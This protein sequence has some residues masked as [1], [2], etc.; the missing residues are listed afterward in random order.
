MQQK[1]LS[2]KVDDQFIHGARYRVVADSKNY[3]CARFSF[4]ECWRGLTKTAVFTGADGAVYHVLLEEDACLVPA[5]VI[6]PARF[7]ISVFGGDRL[8][9]DHAVVEVEASGCAEGVTPPVPT[10]D[11]YAQLTDAVSTERQL[12]QAAA[13][14]AGEKAE[15]CGNAAVMA[16]D[17]EERAASSR[18]EAYFYAAEAQNALE[19]AQ[20][21]AAEASS[22]A[23]AVAIAA[24]TAQT[25]AATATAAAERSAALLDD[26]DG[27][28]QAANQAACAAIDSAWEAQMSA[29]SA[30]RSADAA[31]ETLAEAVTEAQLTAAHPSLRPW[32]LLNDIVLTEATNRIDEGAIATPCEEI[33][34]E[35]TVVGDT[36]YG[37]TVKTA[38]FAIAFNGTGTIHTEYVSLKKGHTYYL[39]A[40][41]YISPSNAIVLD[42]VLAT[43]Y[44]LGQAP[45]QTA[46]VKTTYGKFTR[47]LFTINE[48]GGKLGVRFGAGTKLKVWGR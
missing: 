15:A 20:T 12:A 4:S 8:T 36:D 40:K 1:T 7:L 9:T 16:M 26:T 47:C 48:E 24:D 34:I 31:A 35:G 25:H 33:W 22:A 38:L 2:F 30:K 29:E 46:G 21:N 43:N 42:T 45:K 3:L 27:Y 23:Q 28:M 10:P 19:A 11:I 17:A 41:G 5:E 14:T 6:R 44:Y 18:N 13:V 37:D 39:R 32:T